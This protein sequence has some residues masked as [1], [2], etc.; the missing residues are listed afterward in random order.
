MVGFI[1][2]RAE[3]IYLIAAVKESIKSSNRKQRY[4]K[5]TRNSDSLQLFCFFC[6]VVCNSSSIYIYLDLHFCFQYLKRTVV[7]WFSKDNS[8]DNCFLL[9]RTAVNIHNQHI[10]I[11]YMSVDFKSFRNTATGLSRRRF[12]RFVVTAECFA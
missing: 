5:I 7:T 2:I 10:F 6:M 9:L 3:I 4:C 8:S 12:A 11:L 1:P